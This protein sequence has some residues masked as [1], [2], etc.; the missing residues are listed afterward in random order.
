VLALSVVKGTR[1]YIERL[2][3]QA[4]GCYDHRWFEAC[5]M[6]LRKLVENLIIEVYEAKENRMK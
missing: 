4:N 1:G 3:E 2:V 6:T 5:A